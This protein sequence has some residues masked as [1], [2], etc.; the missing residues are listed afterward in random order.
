VNDDLDARIH[1]L[2]RSEVR[3]APAPPTIAS[4]DSAESL[5]S[6][7]ERLARVPGWGV[8]LGVA[9]VV[10]TM[11][12]GLVAVVGGDD[13]IGGPSGVGVDDTAADWVRVADPPIPARA[14][15]TSVWTGTEVLV[16][17]GDDWWCPPGASCARPTTPPMNDAA[18]YNPTTDQWRVLPDVPVAFSYATT[19]VLLDAVYVSTWDWSGITGGSLASLL[20]YDL[21]LDEWQVIEHP[22]GRFAA[23]AA[24]GPDQLVA[25]VAADED[26]AAPLHVYDQ[27]TKRWS[28]LPA[29]PL[30]D[31][32]DTL[33]TAFEG[34]L[35]QFDHALDHAP[36]EPH[37]T[38]VAQ[39]S[40][41]NGWQ[42]LDDLPMLSTGPWFR[43]DDT[44]L[45]VLTPGREDGGATNSWNRSVPWGGVFDTDSH[46]WSELPEGAVGR[47]A[48]AFTDD[49]ASYPAPVNGFGGAVLDTVRNRWIE[50]PPLRHH[51]ASVVAAGRDAFAFGGVDDD[52]VLVEGAWIWRVRSVDAEPAPP[53]ESTTTLPVTE[54]IGELTQLGGCAD[55][56]FWAATADDTLAITIRI[57]VRDRPRDTAFERTYD[58]A[59]DAAIT[60]EVVEG[61]ELAFCT[62]DPGQLPRI[63]R[64]ETITEGTVNVRIDPPPEDFNVVVRGEATITGAR[65]ADGRSIPPLTITTDQIGFYAG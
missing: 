50:V 65:L 5:P 64:T 3:R 55:A 63:D 17:G 15:T 30:V 34:E 20:R 56:F 12:A 28:D 23:I 36:N 29:S 18:A 33:T 61:A 59:T 16:L 58:L 41:R 25:Q 44:R 7:P 35:Y 42:R 39:Y 57:D 9:T 62:D 31:G 6:R 8:A 47:I 32:Y 22:Y 1:D 11:V 26:D 14:N 45:A 19:A 52:G 49:G 51:P 37:L 24:W 4:I 60:V 10:V 2:I 46:T 43:I 21:V 27:A 13:P 38:R 54:S 48:G 53:T 40:E